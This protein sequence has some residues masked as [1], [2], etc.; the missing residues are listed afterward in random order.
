MSLSAKISSLSNNFKVVYVLLFLLSFKIKEKLFGI[1]HIVLK[2]FK[3]PSCSFT[4]TIVYKS[5]SCN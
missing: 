1:G 4:I 3:M 5:V 2:N